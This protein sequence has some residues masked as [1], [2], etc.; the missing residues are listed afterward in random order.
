MNI[1]TCIL[2]LDML[3]LADVLENFRKMGMEYCGLDALYYYTLPG[4]TVNA[5]LKETKQSLKLIMSPEHL[6][7]FLKTALEAE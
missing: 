4:F 7:F 5:C 2:S 6:I 1:M 3:L